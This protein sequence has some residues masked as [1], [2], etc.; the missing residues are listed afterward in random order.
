[1]YLLLMAV[2][3]K[4][5][6]SYPIQLVMLCGGFGGVDPQSESD[7][8]GLRLSHD[9]RDVLRDRLPYNNQVLGMRCLTYA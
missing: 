4:R 1:M 8:L 7:R 2:P 6:T 5:S 3:K 9:I